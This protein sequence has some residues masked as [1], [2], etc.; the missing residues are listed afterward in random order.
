M[1]R[2]TFGNPDHYSPIELYVAG[3]VPPDNVPDLWVGEGVEWVLDRDGE[4]ELHEG[5]YRI[6][7]PE[8]VRIYTIDDIIA[9]QGERFPDHTQ[10]QRDFRA[11]VILLIDENHPATRSQ[12]D[13]LSQYIDTFTFPGMDRLDSVNFYEA[14][15]GRATITMGDLS[16]FLRRDSTHAK[17]DDAVSAPVF[18]SVTAGGNHACGTTTEGSVVCWGDNSGVKIESPEGE[19][20]SVSAGENHTCGLRTDGSITCW[21]DGFY[22]Q[23]MVPEGRFDSVSAGANHNC[24]VVTNGAVACWGY[25]Y[26]GQATPPD[27]A[28]AS[29]SSGVWHSCGIRTDGSVAC[30]GNDDYGQSTPPGGNSSLSAPEP[31]TPAA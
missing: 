29:V 18:S 13:L 7:K 4:V 14:T 23:Q 30:W 1:R 26:D 11:A 28:F 25:H 19:F 15:E 16:S 21:G 6:F 27:G 9:E 22:R 8:K 5:K 3:L 10:S 12:L 31:C 20:T 2:T 17:D 24:A